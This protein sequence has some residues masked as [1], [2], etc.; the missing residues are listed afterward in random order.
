MSAEEKEEM[1][2]LGSSTIAAVNHPIP[3]S[4][5]T[6]MNLLAYD[7]RNIMTT[8]PSPPGSW[9]YITPSI[10]NSNIGN[11]MNIEESWVDMNRND[12]D[13]SSSSHDITFSKDSQS[14]GILFEVESSDTPKLDTPYN[15]VTAVGMNTTH[16][17]HTSWP[18]ILL[19]IQ[20]AVSISQDKDTDTEQGLQNDTIQ[21]I[22]QEEEQALLPNKND[23]HHDDDDENENS[24]QQ[25]TTEIASDALYHRL[26]SY[27]QPCIDDDDDDTT[28]NQNQTVL[29]DEEEDILFPEYTIKE[30]IVDKYQ[31]LEDLYHEENDE[32]VE[33]STTM[34]LYEPQ[35]SIEQYTVDNDDCS[36]TM[37]LNTNPLQFKL[38]KEVSQQ[39]ISFNPLDMNVN[40]AHD[41][42]NPSISTYSTK[43]IP[44]IQPPPVEKVR[45]WI[46]SKPSLRMTQSSS[47][48]LQM[49]EQH[50]SDNNH[51]FTTTMDN[52]HSSNADIH[53]VGASTSPSLD[54]YHHSYITTE[55]SSNTNDS[56]WANFH[57]GGLNNSE[58]NIP[59]NE[60]SSLS[61]DDRIPLNLSSSPMEL[62]RIHYNIPRN[63]ISP[64]PF[65][66]AII[67]LPSIITMALTFLGDPAAVCHMKRVNRFCYKAITENE[68]V[69]MKDAVR[70]GGLKTTLRPAFWMWITLEKCQRTITSQVDHHHHHHHTLG[71][72]GHLDISEYE[73]YA[74]IGK[75]GKWSVR[76][77]SDV[78]QEVYFLTENECEVSLKKSF[79]WVTSRSTRDFQTLSKCGEDSK[80]QAIIERDVRRA[81]GNMP[82]HKSGA[83]FKA[84]SIVKALVTWG[85][86]RFIK[87][88][89][90]GGGESSPL[91]RIGTIYEAT[92]PF[93]EYLY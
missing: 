7:T 16:L 13:P 17:S 76:I 80:W 59:W 52:S 27:K 46:M 83:K 2:S 91:R 32:P 93:H 30:H 44:L 9:D 53:V 71:H 10:Q 74:N 63:Q 1:E 34:D 84:D 57:E 92:D 79:R 8:P 40:R 23:L 60:N 4:T 26:N 77:D 36:S 66:L 89:V 12:F 41:S 48:S 38:E 70:L 35:G 61:H 11:T 69:L 65:E 42:N 90:K 78:A 54:D 51:S 73:N 43:A 62:E 15:S 82:P 5:T 72:E 21:E 47:T 28:S 6:S 39:S 19:D 3:T 14:Q 20:A 31:Y 67:H 49:I 33:P 58:S 45:K 85:R 25:P 22:Q 29:Q 24:K 50:N 56:D 81:F 64:S 18:D 75:D 86:N 68:H 87:R 55:S 37:I 88:G